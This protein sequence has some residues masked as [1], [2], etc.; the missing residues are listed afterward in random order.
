MNLSS[1]LGTFLILSS[2]ILQYSGFISIPM[3]L[4]FSFLAATQVV[5]EPLN[6]SSIISLSLE[7]NSIIRFGNSNG[8]TA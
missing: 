1:L 4:L 2:A 6:G 5:P 7:N 8:K 3:N